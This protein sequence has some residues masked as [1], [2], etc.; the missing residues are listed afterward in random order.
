VNSRSLCVSEPND[1]KRIGISTT[2]TKTL[3]D[4]WDD[5]LQLE[6]LGTIV[7]L[8]E[9]SNSPQPEQG[10]HIHALSNSWLEE[11]SSVWLKRLEYEFMYRVEI[12]SCFADLYISCPSS[13]NILVDSIVSAIASEIGNVIIRRSKVWGN[14]NYYIGICNKTDL[15]RSIL[16]IY[17]ELFVPINMN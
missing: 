14:R 17:L 7:K 2:N 11:I 1:L 12:R 5:L 13:A 8:C 10:K 9:S 4:I 6:R 3:Q 15:T 16:F